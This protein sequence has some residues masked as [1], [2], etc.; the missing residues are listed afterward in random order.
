MG[1]DLSHQSVMISVCFCLVVKR[2]FKAYSYFIALVEDQ[3]RPRKL[4]VCEDH[5][6]FN[7]I[8][9]PF[10]P[11]QVQRKIDLG[12]FNECDQIDPNGDKPF[13]TRHDNDVRRERGNQQDGNAWSRDFT[14]FLG[15][16]LSLIVTVS[17]NLSPTYLPSQEIAH[18]PRLMSVRVSRAVEIPTA[19][20]ACKATQ[21]HSNGQFS[22]GWW[23]WDVQIMESPDWGV[24]RDPSGCFSRQEPPRVVVLCLDFLNG[25]WRK[26]VRT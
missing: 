25:T 23:V 15:F 17:G 22:G 18:I 24:G 11:C 12:C 16:I 9:W 8:W 4:V 26:R 2:V 14:R 20:M 6:P 7:A 3:W 1:D 5:F 10:L 21:W 19:S 13:C